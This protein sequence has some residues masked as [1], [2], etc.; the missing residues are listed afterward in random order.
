MAFTAYTAV[1]NHVFS[2]KSSEVSQFYSA[3]PGATLL[4]R[5]S[6]HAEPICELSSRP[7]NW[8]HDQYATWDPR[9][10]D[11]VSWSGH[12]Y[13]H[14]RVL[15]F[16]YINGRVNLARC[17][18]DV[19]DVDADWVIFD[20]CWFLWGTAAELR[21][22]LLSQTNPMAREPRMF[23]GFDESD[24][25]TWSR[26]MWCGKYFKEYLRE[27]GYSIKQA[28]WDY[29]EYWQYRGCIAKVFAPDYCMG[30]SL[31]GSG[32]VQVQRGRMSR[33]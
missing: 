1:K 2:Q 9:S 6:Q 4:L 33:S 5:P 14:G 30:E 24:T 13:Y 25:M 23:L 8:V 11:L 7:S 10:V 29:C 18:V 32:P 16:Y 27:P 15:H 31:A 17:H 19:R 3:P 12:T 22:D 20:T 21:A 26:D 28:W